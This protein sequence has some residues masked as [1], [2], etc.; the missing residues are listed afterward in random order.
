MDTTDLI[1][2]TH[3]QPSKSE[4]Q[5]I[6]SGLEQFNLA[7]API[8]SDV[9]PLACTVHRGARLLG[10]VLGRTWGECAELQQLWVEAASRRQGLGAHL[11]REFEASAARRGA[12]RIYLDTFSFQSPQ[13][14]AALGYQ[15]VLEIAGYT[16]GIRKLTML[17]ELSPAA[18]SGTPAGS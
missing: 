16:R 7:A 1:W 11:V 8:A 12:R 13:F 18:S 4:L 3:E 6:D 15:V 10:G 2:L 17:R 5:A 9:R 14:Y